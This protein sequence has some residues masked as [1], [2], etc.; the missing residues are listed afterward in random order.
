MEKKEKSGIFP[1][2]IGSSYVLMIVMNALASLLPIN[3]KTTG[4][5]SDSYPNLFAPAGITF[6]VWGVI[7]LLLAGYVVY[8]FIVFSKNRD[9]TTTFTLIRVG[10]LFVI[11]SIL[12]SV[13]II[14]WHYSFILASTVLIVAI[15]ICLT[16]ISLT[17]RNKKLTIRE[18]LF[19]RLPFSVYFGWIT[20]AVIANITI[21]L[22]DMG[23]NRFGLP[24]ALW[25]LL[26]ILIGAAIAS[27]VMIF[28]K[29]YFYILPVAWAYVGIILKHIDV[30]GFN[31]RYPTVYFAAAVG[32]A[33][34]IL[35]LV[36]SIILRNLPKSKNPAKE[37]D[38]TVKEQLSDEA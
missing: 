12:N 38:K 31:R 17:L 23:W 7:Y 1:L 34:M 6:A 2:L 16:L 11:S 36:Y 3:G 18:K 26:L 24:E 20:V 35:S 4:E 33:M 27:A 19:V 5:V 15:L 28:N 29:D 8:Q 14:T 30:D 10:V 21:L 22:V 25:T 9:A 37:D 13:W 32:I